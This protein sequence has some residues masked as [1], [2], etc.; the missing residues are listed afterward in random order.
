MHLK[1]NNSTQESQTA[2]TDVNIFCFYQLP[3]TQESYF[4][5]TIISHQEGGWKKL[6]LRLIYKLSLEYINIWSEV[7]I[8]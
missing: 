6:I 4:W 5:Y 7:L 1:R 2:I 3:V 8:I